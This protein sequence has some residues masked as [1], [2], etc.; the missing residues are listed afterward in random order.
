M[1]SSARFESTRCN[2][3]HEWSNNTETARFNGSVTIR[4]K[5]SIE[6]FNVDFN[7]RHECIIVSSSQQIQTSI[8]VLIFE[9]GFG[10]DDAACHVLITKAFQHDFEKV[11]NNSTF[12]TCH[13]LTYIRC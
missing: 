6:V 3:E 11:K 12:T 5:R 1:I 8:T 9:N 4:H 7:R 2:M 13:C 10:A